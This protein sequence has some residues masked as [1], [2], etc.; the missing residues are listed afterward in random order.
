MLTSALDYNYGT[1]D[2]I[3]ID[4]LASMIARERERKMKGKIKSGKDVRY[5][6][7]EQNR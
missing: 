2:L 5:E 1:G 6:I 7:A 3:G 4:P